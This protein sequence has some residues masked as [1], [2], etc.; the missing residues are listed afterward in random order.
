M[1]DAHP[2]LHRE[3]FASVDSTNAAAARWAGEH[4]QGAALFTADTQTAGRG[5]WGRDWQSPQGGAWFSLVLRRSQPDELVSLEA[6]KAVI[7]ALSRWVSE[8]RLSLKPPNDV[9]LDERKVAGILCE[10]AVRAA[11]G[12]SEADAPVTL[13]VGVGININLDVTQLGPDLRRPAISLREAVCQDV[14]VK[15]VID[16][17][18]DALMQRLNN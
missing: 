18:V 14:R 3:H 13:I 16:A 6:A 1:S 17:V 2:E 4:P 7:A 10:Q 8:D 12:A 5:Q 11:S 9:L 15:E